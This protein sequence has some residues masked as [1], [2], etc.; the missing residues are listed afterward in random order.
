MTLPKFILPLL[1]KIH[2]RAA[3]TPYFHLTDYMHRDWILG[4]RSPE[5][6]AVNPNWSVPGFIAPAPGRL[7]RWICHH[8]A[9][10]AHTTFRSDRD[11]HLHD[12]PG[13]SVSIVL[14]GGYWEV[15]RHD[16]NKMCTPLLYRSCID[17][18]TQGWMCP[19]NK[20]DIGLAQHFG[21]YWRGPGAIVLRRA[22]MAHRLVLPRGTVS[23]SIF[24]IGKKTN[25]WGF[26]T[27][28]G[29]VGWREYL[30]VPDATERKVSNG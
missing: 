2:A 4:A 9:A 26:Y 1:L 22:T 27:P 12:H 11:R 29:K 16:H 24:F 8:V 30:G 21:I 25:P 7:Y 28:D 15:T 10:R 14:E 17:S 13:W 18:I 19:T 5:R 3:A 23:K 20:R 6:N